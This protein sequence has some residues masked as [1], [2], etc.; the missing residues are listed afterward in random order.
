MTTSLFKMTGI[1]ISAVALSFI[2]LTLAVPGAGW[3]ALLF[4]VPAAAVAGAWMNAR[5]APP[6]FMLSMGAVGL[7]L[8]VLI[9]QSQLP[10]ALAALR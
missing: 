4:A 10:E 3:M 7:T 2:A 5:S 1:L 6:D 8:I 9:M